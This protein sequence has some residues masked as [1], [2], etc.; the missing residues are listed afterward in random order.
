MG[1]QDF[2]SLRTAHHKLR[3]RVI[4][5]RRKDRTGYKPQSYGEAFEKT[6]SERIETIIR[7]RQLGFAGAL[8][9]QSASRLSKKIMFGRPTIQGPKRGGHRRRLVGRSRAKAKDGNGSHPDL[10]SRTD[11]IGL[12]FDERGHVAPRGREGS[13]STR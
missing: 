6:G 1:T 7:R 4:D 13:G 9:W 12:L 2:G 3:L 11:G 10:L 8:V 5:F